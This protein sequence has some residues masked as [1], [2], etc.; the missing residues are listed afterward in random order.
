MFG[1]LLDKLRGLFGGNRQR[2]VDMRKVLF[3]DVDG[4]LNYM[5][6]NPTSGIGYVSYHRL[7]LPECME[8]VNRILAETGAVVVLS[9]SWRRTLTEDLTTFFQGKG[10]KGTVIDKTP[11]FDRTR[12]EEIQDWL[13]RHPQVEQFVILDDGSDMGALRS[14]LVQ[15]SSFGGL[16]E[17]HVKQAIE[18]LNGKLINVEEVYPAKVYDLVDIKE[19][20]VK[21]YFDAGEVVIGKC[22]CCGGKVVVM[23]GFAAPTCIECWATMLPGA[24]P[25]IPMEKP[26]VIKSEKKCARG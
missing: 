16:R 3:L 13:N 1:F 18:V 8:R 23:Q 14:H 22:S 9:S 17:P 11:I 24:M 5:P 25:M 19:Y 6:T 4:V 2:N 7:I 15:T 12:G 21:D 26:I 20:S 10:L